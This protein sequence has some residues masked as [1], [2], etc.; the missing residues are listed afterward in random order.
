MA[1]GGGS[2]AFEDAKTA[3]SATRAG[4]SEDGKGLVKAIIS[5]P[6]VSVESV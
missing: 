1:R 2:Y 6:G 3:F 4:K 5:G